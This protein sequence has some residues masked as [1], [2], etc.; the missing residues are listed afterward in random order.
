MVSDKKIH[1]ADQA[2]GHRTTHGRHPMKMLINNFLL[3]R[4]VTEWRFGAEVD[5]I[6]LWYPARRVTVPIKREVIQQVIE[7][8]GNEISSNQNAFP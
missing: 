8:N 1:S 3:A 4:E 6:S 7:D 2:S 5:H